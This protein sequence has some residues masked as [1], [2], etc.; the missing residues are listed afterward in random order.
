MEVYPYLI[1][2]GVFNYAHLNKCCFFKTPFALQ[3]RN[4]ELSLFMVRFKGAETT[5][6]WSGKFVS[7]RT[8]PKIF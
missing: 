1:Q 2:S 3:V 7:H 4:S 6:L 8:G 5:Q